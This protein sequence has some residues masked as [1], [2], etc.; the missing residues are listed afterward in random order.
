MKELRRGFKTEA[1]EHAITLRSEMDLDAHS[2][3][4][5]W[6]LAEHLRIPVFKLSDV[7]RHAPV[8]VGYLLGAGRDFFSAVTIF[9]GRHK[10]RR[11]IIHNDGNAKT[12]QTSDLA[13]ELS[14][15]ILLHPAISY[16]ERDPVAEAEAAW[17]SGCLLISEHAALHIVRQKMAMDHAAKVYGVSQRLLEW[18]LRMTAAHKRIA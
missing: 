12:R 16:Y 9:S 15:A 18:R 2:P 1:N 13:H 4:C 5:P 3:L 8:H 10:T 11:K 6:R 17:L 7:R 14:H